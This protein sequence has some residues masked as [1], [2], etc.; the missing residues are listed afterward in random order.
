[1]FHFDFFFSIRT[2]DAFVLYQAPNGIERDRV[3]TSM[4]HFSSIWMN[5]VACKL[6][7]ELLT[8]C[9]AKILPKKIKNAMGFNIDDT[10]IIE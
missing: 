10:P 7:K 1:M 4:N 6:T 5:I 9:L 8:R 3:H 2:I